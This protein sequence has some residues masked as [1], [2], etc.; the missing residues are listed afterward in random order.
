MLHTKVKIQDTV[1]AINVIESSMQVLYTIYTCIHVH[2][3]ISMHY[4]PPLS[5]TDVFYVG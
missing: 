2:D 3:R 1:V 4:R 5:V